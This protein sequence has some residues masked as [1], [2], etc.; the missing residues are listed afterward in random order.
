L[1]RG[2]QIVRR[3]SDDDDETTDGARS[4]VPSSGQVKPGPEPEPQ[5]GE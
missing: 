5:P 2:E 4:S 1:L 3:T